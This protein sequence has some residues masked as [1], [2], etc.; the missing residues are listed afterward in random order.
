LLGLLANIL[1]V[2]HFE[3]L[4]RHTKLNSMALVRER[5]IPTERL[6]PVGEVCTDIDGLILKLYYDILK[7]GFYNIKLCSFDINEIF[8]V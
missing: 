3:V 5:T 6:Q 1:K 8:C 2:Q 7:I 4:Y